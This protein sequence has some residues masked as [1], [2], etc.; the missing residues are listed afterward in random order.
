[1]PL[2]NV[3]SSHSADDI[4]MTRD[5]PRL[6]LPSPSSSS[7][8]L[9]KWTALISRTKKPG[10]QIN[11]P[12]HHI[13]T[14]R[15]QLCEWAYLLVDHCDIDRDIVSIAFSIFDRYVSRRSDKE[16]I[17]LELLAL[18]CVYTAI[19]THSCTGKLSS[20]TIAKLSRRSDGVQR[21]T[22]HQI[23]DMEF[24]ICEIVDWHVNPPTPTMFL[25]VGFALIE[26]CVADDFHRGMLVVVKDLAVFLVE[27]S[28]IDIYFAN[29][30]PSSVA[31]AAMLVAT[32]A[33]SAP[34][35]M[36]NSI[37]HLQQ[38]TRETGQCVLRLSQH[39]Q[40]WQSS[41]ESKTSRWPCASPTGVDLIE[42]S[43]VTEGSSLESAF[44]DVV[45]DED[46]ISVPAADN[47]QDKRCV[48]SK[49]KREHSL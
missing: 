29:V 47:G 40:N 21:F 12:L 46:R 39:Y 49:R 10:Y 41:E 4:E 37:H 30:S 44:E 31:S 5:Q 2:R 28:V 36:R 14:P 45:A 1:M 3:V 24:R 17:D 6:P 32:S 19:K 26:E 16:G 27:I 43:Q 23:E 25:D 9:P 11:I 13:Q 8:L 7:D 34:Q 33:L 20:S 15:T 48:S 35:V 22:V 38:D 18:S 42:D